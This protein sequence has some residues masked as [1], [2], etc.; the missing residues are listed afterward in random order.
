MGQVGRIAAGSP[1]RT[2][3]RTAVFRYS[4]ASC[5]VCE[6]TQVRSYSVFVVDSDSFSV[7]A[8]PQR[9]RRHR[10]FEHLD[11]SSAP[12]LSDRISPGPSTVIE[13]HLTK[14]LSCAGCT[15]ANH[16]VYPA[17]L[18]QNRRVCP[19]SHVARPTIFPPCCCV[20]LWE[21]SLRAPPHRLRIDIV[22][23]LHVLREEEQQ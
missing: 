20:A 11:R 17:V 15:L 3:T 19:H 13:L 8:C 7:P 14:V 4:P 9:A 12:G 1:S 5:E 2:H 10:L 16:T 18:T 23:P 6:P 22:I 21:E